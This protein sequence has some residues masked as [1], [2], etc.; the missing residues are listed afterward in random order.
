MITSFENVDDQTLQ[1]LASEYS[2]AIN[3]LNFLKELLA[4]P[5]PYGFSGIPDEIEL[6]KIIFLKSHRDVKID[7][8]NV[9]FFAN[10]EN[11]ENIFQIL[12]GAGYEG[13][14]YLVK[15]KTKRENIDFEKTLRN[16][17]L[18]QFEYETTL[19]QNSKIEIVSFEKL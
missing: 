19:K 17:L 5:F 1:A 4:S 6:L 7:G 13:E 8:L 14:P 15:I 9:H 11:V 18:Y 16:N 2:N 10:P 12:S 3:G